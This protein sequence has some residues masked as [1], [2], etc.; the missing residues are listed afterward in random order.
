[1]ALI[2]IESLLVIF[3]SVHSFLDIYD[4]FSLLRMV[5]SFAIFQDN[6]V[7]PENQL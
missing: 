3:E 5:S 6:F 1:M 7:V 4:T 2:V